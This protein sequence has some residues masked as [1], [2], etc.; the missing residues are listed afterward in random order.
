MKNIYDITCT[1]K[2]DKREDITCCKSQDKNV[3]FL[4]NNNV[5]KPTF[6]FSINRTYLPVNILID[7]LIYKMAH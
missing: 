6:S 2:G 3:G 5:G 1:R 4:L 7:P